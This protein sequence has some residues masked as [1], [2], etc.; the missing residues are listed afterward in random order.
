M[1]RFN[2]RNTTD[3]VIITIILLQG[4]TKSSSYP[5]PST[6]TEILVHPEMELEAHILCRCTEDFTNG[7]CSAA[8]NY[9]KKATRSGHHIFASFWS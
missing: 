1:N 5:S 3:T 9:K 7:D 4:V 8:K 2:A 6:D